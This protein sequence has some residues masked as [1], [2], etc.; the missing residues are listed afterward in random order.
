M[1]FTSDLLIPKS[2]SVF[3]YYFGSLTQ[4]LLADE[5][6]ADVTVSKSGATAA[7]SQDPK[8]ISRVEAPV[9]AAKEPPKAPA[10]AAPP[11]DTVLPKSSAA[12]PSTANDGSKCNCSDKDTSGPYFRCTG[13][14]S[15]DYC[16][17]YPDSFGQTPVL[18]QC[19]AGT[20]CVGEGK[21]IYCL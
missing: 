17:C 20:Q 19:A 10:P 5:N 18:M 14:K 8:P 2:V 3:G 9:P 16:V 6:C 7:P 12:V 1:P 13:K 15:N 21:F 4:C 11:K